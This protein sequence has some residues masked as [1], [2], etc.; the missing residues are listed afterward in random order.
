M[1]R[2]EKLLLSVWS[3]PGPPQ[4]GDSTNPICSQTEALG[5]SIRLSILMILKVPNNL[6]HSMIVHRLSSRF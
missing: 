1:V 2:N 6:S 5:R 4:G 3:Q